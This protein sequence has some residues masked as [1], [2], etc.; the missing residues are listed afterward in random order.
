MNDR[1]VEVGRVVRSK[2][3]RDRKRYFIVLDVLDEQYVLL[4]DGGLR[5][6]ACPKRKKIKHIECMPELAIE[7]AQKFAD[8]TV[9]D[10]E[11]RNWLQFAGYGRP[12]KNQQQE[13]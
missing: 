8:S 1:L 10:A 7:L 2:A 9:Y 4:V 6:L 11:V 12:V 13:E 5:K 3:G